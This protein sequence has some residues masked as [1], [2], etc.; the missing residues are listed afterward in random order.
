MEAIGFRPSP[1]AVI[2]FVH[3][4]LMQNEPKNQDGEFLGGGRC[5]SAA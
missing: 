4:A 5:R 1:H 2:A 3:F